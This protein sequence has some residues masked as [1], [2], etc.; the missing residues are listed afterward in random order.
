[1]AHPHAKEPNMST[2]RTAGLAIRRLGRNESPA[3]LS[4]SSSQD[5]S[6]KVTFVYSALTGNQKI[7]NGQT[8]YE[9]TGTFTFDPDSLEIPAGVTGNIKIKMDNNGSTN[10]WKLSRFVPKSTNPAGGPS[11]A[12]AGSN[13]EIDF[14]DGNTVAGTYAYGVELVNPSNHYYAAYDPTIKQDG[15]GGG[16]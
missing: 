8:W 14:T 7:V 4:T 12:D 5:L 2:V 9:A 11:A 10:G 13:G 16:C 1:M 6:I 15:G 3:I